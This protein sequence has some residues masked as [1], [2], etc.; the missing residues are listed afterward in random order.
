MSD[1][2]DELGLFEF[3]EEDPVKRSQTERSP[4]PW[5]GSKYASIPQLKQH[6]PVRRKWVDHFCGSGIV[7]LNRPESVLEVMNDRYGAI[8][9]FYRCLQNKTKLNQLV[10]RLQATCF[11][12]EEF[13]H[14]RDTW[15]TETDDIE[16]AAK[17][18]YSIR[19]SVLYKGDVW[20]RALNHP[21][22]NQLPD[23]L[24]LFEPVHYRIRNV[25]IENL[26]VFQCIKDYDSFDCVHYFDPP[27]IGTD[28]GMYQDKWNRDKQERLLHTIEHTKGFC[29]LSGYADEQVDSR[30][31]WD[32]RHTWEV[33][34]GGEVQVA[35]D[36]GKEAIHDVR[37]TTETLW[38]KY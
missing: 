15:I 24:K 35:R 11:S 6:L 8:V 28:Q 2:D 12:R 5:L 20:A 13:Y 21:A 4:F 37:N 29:A 30:T 1:I 7:T 33:R 26:D 27:Y 17:W 36:N 25:Q 18:F 23:S 19:C 14:C 34:S 22:P 10:E 16:R 3:I 31:F 38:I 9:A 32:A